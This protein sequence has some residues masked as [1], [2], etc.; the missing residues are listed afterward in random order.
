MFKIVNIHIKRLI[1]Y[2]VIQTYQ[3]ALFQQAAANRRKGKQTTPNS[4]ATNISARAKATAAANK[5]K[6]AAKQRQL[7][8]YKKLKTGAIGSPVKKKVASQDTVRFF[9]QIIILF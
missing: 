2:C 3:A 9:H 4:P 8:S 1:Y 5:A 6:A 7:S